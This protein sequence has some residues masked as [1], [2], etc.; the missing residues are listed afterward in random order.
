MNA[1][2]CVDG[3]GWQ[4][5]LGPNLSAH[6][7]AGLRHR[8]VQGADGRTLEDLGRHGGQ[9]SLDLREGDELALEVHAPCLPDRPYVDATIMK[10]PIP[11]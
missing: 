3:A 1:Q 4:V 7:R 8:L 2:A 6:G 5:E 10:N 11:Y 9:P